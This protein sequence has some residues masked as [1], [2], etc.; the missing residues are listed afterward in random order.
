LAD[1]NE[2]RDL[3][4][5]VYEC[6]LDARQ[7]Q[8][9]LAAYAKSQKASG[10]M[11]VVD[12]V[13]NGSG[14]VTVSHT[15]DPFWGKR[16]HEYYLGVNVWLAPARPLMKPGWIFGGEEMIGDAALQKT[17]FYNDFLRPQNQ[18]YVLGGVLSL[19]HSVSSLISAIRPKAGGPIQGAE[20][21]TT[22]ELVPHLQTALRLHHRIAG[23]GAQLEYASEALDCLPGA[24]IVT[25]CAGRILHMNRRAEALLKSNAGLSADVNGL[26]SGS[27]SRTARLREFIARAASTV[28][29]NGR[30]PG[31][32]LE[33]Q[34]AT[35]PPLQLQIT[36]LASCST[37][38]KRRAA[39]AIFIAEPEPAGQPDA[40]LLGVLLEL[41]PAEARLTAAL[42]GGK[43]IQQFA[44]D[45]AVSI[46]TARTLIGRVFS[47]TGTSR[48]VELVRLALTRAGRSGLG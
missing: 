35:L 40:E 29:G 30:H 11:L 2:I 47:K 22:Q 13:V 24:L 39:V 44:K 12:D 21:S 10:A 46:T 4:R 48:Q 45:A 8:H 5:L 33:I 34:R 31:G 23:L 42:A 7:W 1:E 17:E 36:P 32:V 15:I 38:G 3:I 14:S 26:R 28:T 20:R 37:G 25:D 41:S 27:A 9:F 19:D 18:F 16:Y 6:S 43:T